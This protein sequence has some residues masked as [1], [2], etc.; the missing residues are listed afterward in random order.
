LGCGIYIDLNE[1]RAQ[2][3]ATPENSTN[4]S[5]YIRILAAIKRQQRA[6]GRQ[7][8]PMLFVQQPDDLDYWLCPVGENECAVLLGPENVES[9]AA[10]QQTL[11]EI[12]NSTADE[13]LPFNM[14]SVIKKWRHGFLPFS[15]D[16]Y[17][18]FLDWNA[19]Q[20][21]PGKP[22]VMDSATPPIL[23][24]LGMTPSFWL[25]MI[26]NFDRWFHTAAGSSEK[27]M[28]HA[29]RTGRQW[30]QG[31]GPMRGAVG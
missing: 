24:R 9:V 23:E 28:E 2:L 17:L 8:L 26:E 11:D 31:V 1:I 12:Q 30:L 6:A 25:K 22:G 18:E 3:A 15:L 4:T 27:L 10:S 19:R 14:A 21:L 20:L 5:A 7:T 13:A 16:E 29:A